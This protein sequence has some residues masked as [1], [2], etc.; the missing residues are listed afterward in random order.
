MARFKQVYQHI[1]IKRRAAHISRKHK[2]SPRRTILAAN[3]DNESPFCISAS[4]N[5]LPDNVEAITPLTG[6]TVPSNYCSRLYA[7]TLVV[8]RATQCDACCAGGTLPRV[9]ARGSNEEE[10]LKK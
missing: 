6:D 7:P 5:L 8:G 1:L 2:Q 10:K 4:S 3:R 9:L